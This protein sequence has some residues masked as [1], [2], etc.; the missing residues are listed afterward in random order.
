MWACSTCPLAL[1][2]RL[3]GRGVFDD[4][5]NEAVDIQVI[6]VEDNAAPTFVEVPAD[7][8]I[9]CDAAVPASSVVAADDCGSVPPASPMRSEDGE[10]AGASTIY[11]TL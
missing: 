9:A 11:R 1:G 10:C 7:T 5:G 4:C 3:P 2:I 6:T 8:T